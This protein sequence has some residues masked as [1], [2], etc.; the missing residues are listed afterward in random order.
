MRR[1]LLTALLAAAVSAAPIAGA[2][3]RAQ[4]TA[5]LAPAA[6]AD[7]RRAA[8]TVLGLARAAA[9]QPGA[10]PALA[11]VLVRRGDTPLIWTHGRLS[12]EAGAPAADADTPLYVASLTNAVMGL[13]A[14]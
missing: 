13:L 3:V 12:A 2:P 6:G 4:T 10:S 9:E 14:V 8:E 11:V 7:F 5:A 1:P